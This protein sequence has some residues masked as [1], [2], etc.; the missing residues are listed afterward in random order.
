MLNMKWHETEIDL[1]KGKNHKITIH[2][3]NYMQIRNVE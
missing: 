1:V 3:A 2:S